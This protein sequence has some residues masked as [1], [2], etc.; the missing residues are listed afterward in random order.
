M[1]LS[2]IYTAIRYVL[3]GLGGYVTA[4]FAL[5]AEQVN[6]IVTGVLTIIP[7]VVGVVQTVKNKKK[8]KEAEK[9]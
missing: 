3:V 7:A 1:D 6:A 8:I 2:A 5:D 9:V 4:K